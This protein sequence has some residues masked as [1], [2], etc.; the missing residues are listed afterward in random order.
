MDLPIHLRS[1]RATLIGDAN[2]LSSFKKDKNDLLARLNPKSRIQLD[3]RWLA[4]VEIYSDYI[5][6]VYTTS[7]G[8]PFDR[9]ADRKKH[10]E[11][12]AE[13]FTK[14]GLAMQDFISHLALQDEWNEFQMPLSRKERRLITGAARF[15]VKVAEGNDST[16]PEVLEAWHTAVREDKLTSVG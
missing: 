13:T 14:V 16:W 12:I 4:V 9:S 11:E 3:R 5:G 15:G 7:S 10:L 1:S 6:H 8:R 2:I